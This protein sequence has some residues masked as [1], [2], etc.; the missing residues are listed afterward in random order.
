MD[1]KK[2][3]KSGVWFTVSNFVMKS[4]GLITTPIFT[5]MMS[6]AE[7]GDFSNFQTWLMIFLY[8]SSLDLEASLIR[9]VY[10]F[11]D[12]IDR[13]VHSLIS[14]SIISV[15]FFWVMSVV[16]RPILCSLLSMESI[17][18]DCMFIYL[19]FCPA[20]NIFQNAERFKYKYKWTVASSL[21]ISVGASLLSVILVVLMQDNLKGRVVGYI[22]PTVIVGLIIVV[23]YTVKARPFKIRYWEYALPITLPYIPHLLSMY[24]LSNMDRVMIKRF[25][26]SD[27]VALYS[28]AY[29]CGMIITI[30]VT[31]VNSAYSP[32]LAEKL[33][34]KQYE[35]TR[36]VSVPY[37]LVFSVFALG[38]V[39]V[40]PEVLY[41]LGGEPYLEAKYVMPP[42][43]AG[44]LLQFIYCM[45]VNVEQYEK[46][47]VGMAVAS[48]AAAGVN[49]ILNY[50]L[51]PIYGYI[52]AAYTTYAGYLLLLVL[53]MF[54]VHRMGMSIAYKNRT[55]FIMAICFS[56]IIF[57]TNALLDNTMLRYTVIAIYGIS[58]LVI[59]Y[60]NC[61]T[62]KLILKH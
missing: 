4:V 37:V 41:I 56:L 2:V 42:V 10:D 45:Y 58:V 13:Y 8:V 61:S 12:D 14:L 52:A 20:V 29:T 23:Y 3:L 39:L 22:I 51:I 25:W 26:G 15:G 50:W 40:T 17:Y 7:F 30:F 62:I 1:E 33:S 32:W 44:C 16:A 47:T 46:K 9:A 19:L 31:A 11:K 38:A 43:A 5:R 24:L 49:F 59:V 35:K 57:L 53:H 48:M 6:K 28:L 36:R 60:K 27:Y 55:I 54:F 34:Q 21:T 18:I